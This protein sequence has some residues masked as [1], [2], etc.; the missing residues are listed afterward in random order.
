M[1]IKILISI[2]CGMILGMCSFSGTAM[3]IVQDSL[4]VKSEWMKQ[5]LLHFQKDSNALSDKGLQN[6]LGDHSS[7]PPATQPPPFSFK[8]DEADSQ[9][10]L[11]T[12]KLK[13]DRGKL[14]DDRIQFTFTWT[15]P[16]TGLEVR[17][18]GVE[19]VKFPTPEMI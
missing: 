13:T 17:C 4:T 19:Y 12:W 1:K 14:D 10:F 11:R 6:P 15:D 16:K 3:D 8:Y 7:P 2:S 9:A 5:N 18:A